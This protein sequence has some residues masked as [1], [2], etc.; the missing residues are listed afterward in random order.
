MQL[1]VNELLSSSETLANQLLAA[2]NL[3]DYIRS[4]IGQSEASKSD[5]RKLSGDN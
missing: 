5:D 3:P 2:R 1:N 4:I